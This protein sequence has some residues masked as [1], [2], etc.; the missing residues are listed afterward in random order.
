MQE[1]SCSAAAGC[2]ARTDFLELLVRLVTVHEFQRQWRNDML[3]ALISLSETIKN[4]KGPNQTRRMWNHSYVLLP[5]FAT[6]AQTLKISA[7]SS[8]PSLKFASVFHMAG[9]PCQH[10]LKWYF[11]GLYECYYELHP[12][13]H[14]CTLWRIELNTRNLQPQLPQIFTEKIWFPISSITISCFIST[15][16]IKFL[17]VLSHK[18]QM[19]Y[20]LPFQVPALNLETFRYDLA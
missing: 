9:L 20:C 1:A 15:F 4:H 18:M 14:L 17:Q 10:S 19:P 13:L 16:P 7:A 3:M 12:C 6:K 8:S 5:K 2:P 11:S